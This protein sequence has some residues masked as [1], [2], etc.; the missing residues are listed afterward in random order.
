MPSP[1]PGM[2]PYLEHPQSWPNFHHRL[3]TA[4]AIDLAPQL[5]PKY[6]VIVE[7]A[8]YQTKGQDS[9]LVGKPDA[10]VHKSV[11]SA[12]ASPS[13]TVTEILIAQPLEVELPM[14]EV[15]RQG[16]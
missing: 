1:L 13:P 9:L 5:R 3:I 10:A 2:D 16:Y 6:R 14:V 8:I 12:A 4:I 7:E 11:L 15:I